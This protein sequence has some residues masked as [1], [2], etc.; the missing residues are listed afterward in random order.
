MSNI[1]LNYKQTNI[2]KKMIQDYA[3]KVEKIIKNYIKEL[4]MI[5]ILL[6]G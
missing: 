4:E 5:M 6:G 2:T 1:K 3:K